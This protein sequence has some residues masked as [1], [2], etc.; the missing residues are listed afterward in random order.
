MILFSCKTKSLE[1]SS[2]EETISIPNLVS[3]VAEFDSI[4]ATIKPGNKII[5]AN[6]IWKDAELNL[7]A[8]GTS[9]EHIFIEAQEK[10]KVFFEGQS[11]LKISGSYIH[12]E[13]LVFRNGFTTSGSVISFRTS[14]ESFCNNCRVTECV[15]DDYNPS[16]RHETDYWVE[17]YGK[18]NR[19][20]HNYLVGKRNRGV[21]LAVRMKTEESRENNHIIDYNHFGYRQILGSNGG[22]TLRIGTSHYSLSNSNTLVEN[23]FFERCN[24][25][26]EIISSKSCQNTFRN[27][28]FLECQGTLT[29]RHGNE[30]LV[31][32]NYFFGNRKA[33]TGGIRIINESQTVRNNYCEGLTGSRFKGALVIMNGVPDSPINRY[34]Q[35][36]NSKAENNLIIDC[37]HIQLC[38]GSDK[39][40]SATPNNTQMHSNIFYNSNNDQIFK[41]YDDVSGIDFDKNILSPNM[42]FP[43]YQNKEISRGF[44][45]KKLEFTEQNG[46][47]ICAAHP[48]I[49]PDKSKPFPSGSNT[50]VDWYPKKDYQIHFNYGNK[51]HVESGQNTLL[52][53]V[54]NSKPG[55]VIILESNGKYHQTK[56]L[57]ILHNLTIKSAAPENKAVISFE[58]ASLFNLE[59]RGSLLLENLSVI[60]DECD[61]YSGNSVIR[62]SRYSMINNY[63]LKLKNCDFLNLD[64]NHSFD[65]LRV[66]K[67]SFADSIELINCKFENISGNVLNLDKEF[68]DVGIY[69][70][71]NVRIEQCQFKDIGGVAIKLYRGGRDES[72]FGPILELSNSTFENIGFDKRNK[73]DASIML[74]GVQ[75]A[76]INN[77]NFKN[78]KKIDLHLVVG[79]PVIKLRNI[80]LEDCEKIVSNDDAYIEENVSYNKSE[81]K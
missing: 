53:A 69:N 31:E 51:I 39:E 47:K 40:R 42:S 5:L 3:N 61:D 41:V 19:F 74:H 57:P 64:I 70:V 15:I 28:S 73:N 50:G 12:V 56:A 45:K 75:Y 17:I 8:D 59:N 24:G 71:E 48:E 63:K 78:T 33:N 81:R 46:L 18:N 72:T 58:R 55:D 13:G 80:N 16:E 10:G 76:D 32:N 20:D 7:N 38:A 11:S 14:K 1:L 25:E 67:N 68:E 66:Y 35:V 43:S 44:E 36:T 2:K 62:S 65:V 21:T 60:G 6:G 49:G 37:D 30:T 34:F 79:D 29:M 54:E 52:K 26:L 9:N 23:N 27:N 77:S 22:E 4:K